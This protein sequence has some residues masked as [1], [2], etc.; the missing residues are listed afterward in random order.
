MFAEMDA[1]TKKD[2]AIHDRAFKGWAAKQMRARRLVAFLVV[3]DSGDI[4]GGGSVWLRDIQPFAGY[5]GGKMPY[6]MSMYTDPEYRKKG[7]GGLVVRH[8]VA[9]CRARGFTQMNLH[10][11]KMGRPLYEK[12]GWKQANE[13]KLELN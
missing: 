9:W 4:V 10:A 11:S 13:M 1:R 7:V 5:P 3:N 2:L 8:A 6:L 12:L